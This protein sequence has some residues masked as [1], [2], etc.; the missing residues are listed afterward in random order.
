ME[1][2]I[3][4]NTE[5]RIA[6]D[7]VRSG[8]NIFLTGAGGT[9]KSH[10]IRAIKLW[11]QAENK[12][13]SITAMTG[14][15]ALLLG[16]GAK[17]LHSWAGIGLARETPQELAAIVHA[18]RRS[19]KRW[20]ETQILILDEVSMMTPDILEKLDLIARRVRQCPDIR[21]GGIQLVLS[22][23][24]CQ[25]PP[26]SK[27]RDIVFAFESPY[28]KELIDEVHEL[29]QIERQSDP[30]FQQ[31]LKEAR[32]GSLCP[33]SLHVLQERSGLSWQDNEILPTLLFTRNADVEKINRVNLDALTGEKRIFESQTV[34]MDI[35]KMKKKSVFV[36]P[37]SPEVKKSLEHMD[38]D[39]Q[40]MKELE[41]RVGA[42]VMLITN[43]DQE[44]NLV[45]GSRG[46]VT[47]YSAGGLPLV[48]FLSIPDPII[49]D[50]A[51]WWL[52]EHEGI[53][54]SQI[55]LRVA[56]AMTI[57]RSQGAT[58][59]SALIDIGSNTF[60]YGQAYVALSRVRTL[61]GLYIWK[62]DPTKIR[63]HPKVLAFYSPRSPPE[64]VPEL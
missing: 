30:S 12:L 18:N 55:P 42:Q 45:N 5:Q 43:L 7:A 61:Q 47:G 14:C 40:Y 16:Q 15:A 6:L 31:I 28:W 41:L 19:K 51:S 52:S 20:C 13:C 2:S 33:D 59:D 36:S 24:F 35:K 1:S 50:R 62:I 63:C 37:N 11:A 27:N 56:Y 4:L 9:G 23:D 32:M 17:T 26:V 48:R 21:F 53:G 49:V 10:T 38:K 60:E 8:K 39:A 46:V 29:D 64:N 25:L 58:L 3:P 44:R 22:G 34:L 57:H 54:R